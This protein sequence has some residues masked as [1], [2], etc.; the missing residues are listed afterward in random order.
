MLIFLWIGRLDVF[1]HGLTVDIRHVEMA[2]AL[3]SVPD[4]VHIEVTLQDP[5]L[6]VIWLPR[7][8]GHL[9]DWL[10]GSCNAGGFL[11]AYGTWRRCGDWAGD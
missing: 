5:L 4:L 2:F 10:L 9:L 3:G 7:G 8:L 6:E 1:R 11:M